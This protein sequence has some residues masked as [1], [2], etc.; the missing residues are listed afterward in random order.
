MQQV[1]ARSA[2][3]G[4]GIV[5]VLA[6]G[7]SYL[8]QAD[9]R[10]VVLKRLDVDCLISGGAKL[11]PAIRDRLQRVRE[12][13]Q[14]QVANFHG[15]QRDADQE[16]GAAYLIWEYLPGLTLTSW[17]G[18]PD[19]S[20]QQ[21]LHCTRELIATVEVLH[22][23]GLVHGSIH[24]RN[25]F[26]DQM[27]RPR[28]THISLLLYVDPQA[29]VVALAELLYNMADSRPDAAL[30][31][32]ELADH[33]LQPD[34]SPRSLVSS[35]SSLLAAPSI[36]A[37]FPEEAPPRR[38]HDRS[39]QLAAVILM[40]VATILLCLGLRHWVQTVQVKSPTP[41]SASAAAMQP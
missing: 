19:V 26:V 17:A 22:A 40:S 10:Q 25:I 27:G 2:I 33:A 11:H 30:T 39:V 9:A 37:S 8:A 4:Y 1:S 6:K 32:R 16:D 12:L 36:T 7:Q 28:L 29:D 5:R 20:T 41:P 38:L 23:W 18:R 14:T 24:G 3:C 31:L 15:V 13:A 21:L 34:A 35:A